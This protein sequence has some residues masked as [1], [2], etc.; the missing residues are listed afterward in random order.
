M[1]DQRI[2]RANINAASTL[3]HQLVSTLCGLVIP[4]I[5]IDSFGSVA[6]GVTVSV[7]QFLSYITLFEGGIGR[8]ARG[9]LYKPLAQRNE[10]E[11][12]KVYLAVKRFFR[13]MGV[14]FIGYTLILAVLYKYIADVKEFSFWYIFAL[15]VFISIGRFAEYMGGITNITL[16]NADQKQYIV[17]G[18]IVVSNILNA[19][20]VVI[21]IKLGCDILWVKLGSSLVF[22]LKPVFYS[23]Y[24]KKNYNIIKSKEKTKLPNRWTGLGQ[25][26]AYFIQNNTDIMV[27]TILAGDISYVAVY[28]VYFLVI[29][30]IRNITSSFTG[31]MEALFGDMYAK[32]EHDALYSAYRRFKM[33]LTL[34]TVTLFGVTAFLILP[35]VKLYTAGVD[36]ANYYQPVFAILLILAEAINCIGLPCFN[37]PIAANKLKESRM[38]AYGEAFINITLSCILVVIL[39]NPLLGVAV[40]TLI[41][42]VFK[43]FFYLIFTA[44]NILKGKF[45]SMLTGFLLTLTVLFAVCILSIWAVGYITI[46][47]YFVWALY[48]AAGIA[49]CGALA[50]ILSASLYPDKIKSVGKIL[51]RR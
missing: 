32:D 40:G 13:I 14:A 46:N 18:A 8:V 28:S 47:N 16:F 42:S 10:L 26:M 9:A 3:I 2:K 22:V 24:L 39:D 4:W 27:L 33:I 12:S 36:D 35:F 48:G 20:T 5:M 7:A 1:K 6:Y 38:G 49:V 17:Y 21:L 23:L 43:N 51:K 34:I 30:S 37:L 11:I 50:F 25:H 29:S 45:I 15:V 31:G 19:A 41:A 44:K